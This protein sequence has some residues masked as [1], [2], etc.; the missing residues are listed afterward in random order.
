MPV[1]E[2]QQ[3]EGA[4]VNGALASESAHSTDGSPLEPASDDTP[5]TR[6]EGGVTPRVVILCLVLAAI[7]GYIIPIIDFKLRNTYL[8]ATHLPPGA[9][10]V[11]LILVLLINPALRLISR[12]FALSRNESLTVY[13]TCLF[14]S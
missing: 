10:G 9:I 13:I 4:L 14:S 6:K 11:L 12:K 8:G 7:L 1:I 3:N 5:T 2:K